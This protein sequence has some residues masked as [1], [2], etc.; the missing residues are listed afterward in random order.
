LEIRLLRQND[1]GKMIVIEKLTP[2]TFEA[3][4]ETRHQ[5][6]QVF[7]RAC[8]VAEP[9]LLAGV[10]SQQQTEAVEHILYGGFRGESLLL[11]A[12]RACKDALFLHHCGRNRGHAN[13]QSSSSFLKNRTKK[14]LRPLR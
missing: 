13:P 12:C 6:G 1:L 8:G 3:A 11:T 7:T 2:G 14:L 5:A 10:A 9:L 4:R